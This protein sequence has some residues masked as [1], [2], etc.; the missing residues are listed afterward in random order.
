MQRFV[1][2][3]AAI[4]ATMGTALAA[5][6]TPAGCDTC[7]LDAQLNTG[8]ALPFPLMDLG[9][10]TIPKA[11]QP[12][13]SP[14]TVPGA[15]ITFPAPV[16]GPYG[17]TGIYGSAAD[18]NPNFCC[19]PNPNSNFLIAQTGQTGVTITYALPQRGLNLLWG[20]IG[21]APSWRDQILL[22][23]ADG[24]T[25]TVIGDDV[26]AA[27]PPFNSSATVEIT[28]TKPF[29]TAIFTEARPTPAFEFLPGTPVTFLA[30]TPGQTNCVGVSVGALT[31]QFGGLNAAASALNEPS[32]RAL[33]AA[34]MTYCGG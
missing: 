33:Q 12:I 22:V 32:V 26:V 23:F 5:S 4:I 25:G 11:R 24:T 3:A 2:I 8:G 21:V 13:A 30:G 6:V 20:S 16:S 7:T 17:S 10:A 34:I 18:W 15:T 28:T 31:Q 14:V 27:R 19:T 29:T 1:G 9:T